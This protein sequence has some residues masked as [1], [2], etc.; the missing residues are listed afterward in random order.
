MKKVFVVLASLLMILSL[1]SCFGSNEKEPEP[2]QNE[3]EEEIEEI[4]EAE[5][6]AVEPKIQNEPEVL[7]T[8]MIDRIDGYTW[9][10]SLFMSVSLG[11]NYDEVKEIAESCDLIVE[12]STNEGNYVLA[13]TEKD[14]SEDGNILGI[15]FDDDDKLDIA[16]YNIRSN[17]WFVQLTHR[18]VASK[19]SRN[20]SERTRKSI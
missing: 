12:T 5:D 7:K 14:I 8:P 19:S 1:S 11:Q 16:T 17:R 2:F 4:E 20:I 13:I 10:Q 6:V 18:K 3:T 9:L 15:S